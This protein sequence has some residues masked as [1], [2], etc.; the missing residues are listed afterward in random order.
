MPVAALIPTILQEM[1]MFSVLSDSHR[2]QVRRVVRFVHLE[3]R[4]SLFDYLEPAKAFFVLLKGRIK[5]F[6]VSPAGMEKVVRIIIPGETIALEVMFLEQPHH[7]VFAATLVESDLLAVENR[8]FLNVLRESPECCFRVMAEMSRRLHG[9][10]VEIHDLSTQSAPLRTVRYLI[11]NQK[12]GP[13]SISGMVRLDADKR[14]IASRLSIQPETFSRILARL[15]SLNLIKVAGKNI[16]IPDLVAL[17]RF[18]EE[19]YYNK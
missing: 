16:V 8:T 3:E 2:Q 12:K 6:H 13:D 4:Q 18:A 7:P 9:Q 17:E 5:L 14:V 11:S 19:Q 10:L 1:P 15:S